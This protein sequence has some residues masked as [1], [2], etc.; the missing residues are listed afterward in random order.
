MR[1]QLARTLGSIYNSKIQGE[2]M[3]REAVLTVFNKYFPTAE[4]GVEK[5]G[6]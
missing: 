5:N 4:E 1:F 6:V 2:K 3:D